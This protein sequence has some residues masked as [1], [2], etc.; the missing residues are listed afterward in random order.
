MDGGGRG[1]QKKQ[2]LGPRSGRD[3]GPNSPFNQSFQWFSTKNRVATPPNPYIKVMNYVDLGGL[4]G[5]TQRA[6]GEDLEVKK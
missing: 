4:G 1:G 5:W 6:A 3:S 2:K